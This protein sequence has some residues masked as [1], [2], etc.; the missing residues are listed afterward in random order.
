VVAA[1][2][3]ALGDALGDAAACDAADG[4]PVGVG[5]GPV[6]LADPPHPAT[7]PAIAAI[8]AARRLAEWIPIDVRPRP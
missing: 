8:T 3:V 1:G 2:D 6:A 4:D 5:A 7:R